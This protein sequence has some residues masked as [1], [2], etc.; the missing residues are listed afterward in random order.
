MGSPGNVKPRKPEPFAW[1]APVRQIEEWGRSSQVHIKK[2]V[3]NPKKPLDI[4][5][6]NGYYVNYKIGLTSLLVLPVP[7][8]LSSLT[9]IALASAPVTV[10][11]FFGNFAELY[12]LAH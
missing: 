11:A 8:F 6:D 12:K 7:A 1:V 4:A 9:R 2:C 3:E 10:L 5:S